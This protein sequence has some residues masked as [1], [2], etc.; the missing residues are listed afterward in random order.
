MRSLVARSSTGEAFIKNGV[1]VARNTP[2]P[3]LD[4]CSK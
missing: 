1:V 3:W 4:K 2:A